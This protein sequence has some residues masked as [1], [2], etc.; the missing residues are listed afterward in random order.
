[1]STRTDAETIAALTDRIAVAVAVRIRPAIPLAIDI[2]T[3]AEIGAYLKVA[4]TKVVERFAS[5][6]GFPKRFT[7][8]TADGR[9][10]RPRWKAQEVVEWAEGYAG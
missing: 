4:P 5:L 7:L 8:P 1:M 10:T 9:M 2:W 6:P 3:T